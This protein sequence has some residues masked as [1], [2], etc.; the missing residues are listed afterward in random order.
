MLYKL[1]NNLHQ[2]KVW[3]KYVFLLKEMHDDA[4]LT[5]SLDK[6]KLS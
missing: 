5:Q 4:I 1:K 3:Q 6:A 2:H